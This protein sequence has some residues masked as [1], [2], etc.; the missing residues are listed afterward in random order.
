MGQNKRIAEKK[1]RPGEKAIGIEQTLVQV[2]G[3][4]EYA[5]KPNGARTAVMGST[6]NRSKRKLVALALNFGKGLTR[7]DKDLL[8]LKLTDDKPQEGIR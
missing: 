2:I 8:G 3:D 1:G 6:S 7:E 5:S 4:Y